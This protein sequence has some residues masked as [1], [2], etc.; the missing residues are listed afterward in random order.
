MHDPCD[1]ASPKARHRTCWQTFSLWPHNQMD[2]QVV[3]QLWRHNEM[4]SK[5]PHAAPHALSLAK[6][7]LA[8]WSRSDL[9]VHG[10]G[11][12]ILQICLFYSSNP[13]NGQLASG[14]RANSFWQ[15]SLDTNWN[16]LCLQ[17]WQTGK[18]FRLHWH[19]FVRVQIYYKCRL[20]INR[21]NT[22]SNCKAFVAQWLAH[23]PLESG[24]VSSTPTMNIF[25]RIKLF[26]FISLSFLFNFLNF[27]VKQCANI[28]WKYDNTGFEMEK[29]P[30]FFIFQN[31]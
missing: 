10:G 31:G 7:Q 8:A 30:N 11:G 27:E 13:F 12:T 3:V 28:Y 2:R 17:C 20:S 1:K 6:G 19:S 9:L 26:F 23:W 4:T 16:S 18:E 21:T 24:I 15:L 29:K 25:L 22:C 14:K 5:G